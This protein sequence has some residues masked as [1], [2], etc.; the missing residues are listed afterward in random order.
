M[1]S[2]GQGGTDIAMFKAIF[3][4]AEKPEIARRVG[5]RV[6]VLTCSKCGAGDSFFF[7]KASDRTME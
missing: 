2:S 7:V 4:P 1:P 5:S 3:P 6:M